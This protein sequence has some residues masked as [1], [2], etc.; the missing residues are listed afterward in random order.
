MKRFMALL[1]AVVIC[2]SITGCSSDKKAFEVSKIAYDNIKAAYDIAYEF[3]SDLAGVWWAVVYDRDNLLDTNT[4]NALM[5]E[6]SYLD[7]ESLK[8]GIAYV[9]AK[10]MDGKNW[11]E[12]SDNEKEEYITSASKFEG[13]GFSLFDNCMNFSLHSIRNAYKLNGRVEEARNYLEVAK[14]QMQELSGK[15]NDYEHYPALK[16]FYTMAGAYL[17]A[18]LEARQSFESFSDARAEYEKEARDYIND[19]DF[20]FGG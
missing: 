17:D 9:M 19:L 6:L 12:L 3:A 14:T 16:G 15:Y 18:C 2:F 4:L 7:E 20:V 5:S 13:E 11:D 8:L 1:L 10:N